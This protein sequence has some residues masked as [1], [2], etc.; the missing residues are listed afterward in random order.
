MKDT[1]KVTESQIN[2]ME[3]LLK[4]DQV[5]RF[6]QKQ[7]DRQRLSNKFFELYFEKYGKK[8]KDRGRT[9]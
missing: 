4:R 9:S 1:K 2:L 5:R 6:Y 7:Y 3:I 8:N